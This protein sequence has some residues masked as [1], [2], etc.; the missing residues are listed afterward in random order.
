MADIIIHKDDTLTDKEA[1]EAVLQVVKEGRISRNGECYC[2]CA[3]LANG[4]IVISDKKKA[5]IFRV[6]KA[7]A[8]WHEI[9]HDSGETEM[10]V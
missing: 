2:F 8:D 4:T 10:R 3:E 6:E 1:L 7:N 5:D 9:F